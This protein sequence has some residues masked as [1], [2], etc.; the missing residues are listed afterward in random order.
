M[1]GM[2][3]SPIASYAQVST[4]IAVETA[5]PHRLILMLFDGARTAIIMARAHMERN[6]IA[7]KG[8]AISKAID[9]VENGLLASLD[10]NSGG[11]LAERLAALYQY[12]SH[13]L[14]WAN[15]KNNL[16]AL[17]EANQLLGELQSAWAMI[18]PSAASQAAAAA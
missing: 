15:L 11:E 3:R 1:F 13:R 10:V 7:E 17:D 6:E 8:A 12:I 18:G 2:T 4:N 9:I 16:A 14:L 5:D